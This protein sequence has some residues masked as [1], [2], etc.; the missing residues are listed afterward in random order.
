MKESYTQGELDALLAQVSTRCGWDFSSMRTERQVV[1]WSYEDEVRLYT[2]PTDHVLDIGTGGGE[3]LSRLASG[4][5]VGLGVDIDPAMIETAKTAKRKSGAY[6]VDFAVSSERLE[7]VTGMFDV[8]IDRH[9]P[10]DLQAVS[11]HLNPG[12]YFITQQVGENNM[13]NVKKALGQQTVRPPVEKSQ[14]ERFEGLKLVAFMEYDVEYVVRDIGS[15]VFWFSALDLLHADVAG[16]AALVGAD[17]LNSVLRG[18][19]SSRGFATNEHR[20]LVIAQAP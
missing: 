15:L 5:A 19:V 10:F 8:V 2:K 6:N 14:I 4:F 17:S 3:V 9:A 7:S 16:P 1:P 12:G 13:A 11:S 18:A 20:Y